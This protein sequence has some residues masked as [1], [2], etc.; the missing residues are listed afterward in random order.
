MDAILDL[1]LRSVGERQQPRTGNIEPQAVQLAPF[2]TWWYPEKSLGEFI[3]V[4]ERYQD[5]RRS[6]ALGRWLVRGLPLFA[7]PEMAMSAPAATTMLAESSQ[8]IRKILNG[9][10]SGPGFARSFELLFGEKPILPPK[11][12]KTPVFSDADL[13]AHWRKARRARAEQAM[14]DSGRQ[15]ESVEQGIL[16]SIDQEFPDHPW[17]TLVEK[18]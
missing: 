12:S 13:F 10:S 5:G 2:R 14:I 4:P 8:R 9:Q 11:D 3:G 7:A 18:G 1:L 15:T 17:I 6:V 16:K